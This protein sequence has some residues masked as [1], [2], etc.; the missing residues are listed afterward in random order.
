VSMAEA[1]R[2]RETAALF[3]RAERVIPGGIYGHQSPRMLVPGAYPY[4]F[5]R[6]DG[7]RVWDVDGNEYLDLVCGYGPI[8]LGHNH[9]AVDAAAAREAAN[10]R[11]Y[12]G[13]GRAFVELAERLVALTPWAAWAV[14]AKNGS[15]VCTWATQ[16]ARA[17][18]GKTKILAAKGAY[19]GTHAWCAPMPGGTTPEDRAHVATY[20][21]N[22]LA[23]VDRALAMHDG[24]VAGIIVSPFRH[25]AFHDQEMPAPGF[26]QGLRERC[27]A[28][29]AVLIL[30]DVR[31]GFRLSL[32]G[33]GDAM[34]V[35][36]DLTCYCKALGNGYAISAALGRESLRDAAM[37]V[38]FTGS[39]WTGPVEMAAALACLATLEAE[40]AI[41]HMRR[42]GTRLRDGMVG[43]GETHGTPVHWSGPPALPFMTFRDDEGS[44]T[45]SRLFAAACAA[46]GVY[47][48]PHHNW[49]V[50]AAL[51]DAD[52]DR[53][54]DVTDGAFADVARSP[55]H[56]G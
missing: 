44:F 3:A 45:R 52:V 6:G 54:L 21:Y 5:A 32:A 29:G 23:T 17:A 18:T 46:R 28:R 16:V 50:S 22:D 13:P 55:E 20:R 41:A 37:R 51:T 8:V 30:D 40:G 35:A 48:H 4:F 56:R 31:A 39:Y 34:G 12:N 38:F 7:A 26:L 2:H 25:D 15:D 36:P 42:I 47:L 49:F 11:C 10:G 19:H 53:I 14:F 1:G 27:D 9:P 43:Q 33:S 24:D